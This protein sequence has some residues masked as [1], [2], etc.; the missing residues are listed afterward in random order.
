MPDKNY[1][2][3]QPRF[4]IVV[5]NSQQIEWC[6]SSKEKFR[7][8]WVKINSGMNRLGFKG[9]GFSF[10]SDIK[11]ILNQLR[12]MCSRTGTLG[13]MTHFA[14]GESTKFCLEQGRV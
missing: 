2:K 5:H 12:F 10:V 8:I 1:K 9:S 14:V 7:M 3:Y 13:W 6:L 4:E 11:E